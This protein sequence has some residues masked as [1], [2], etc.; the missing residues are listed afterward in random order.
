MRSF[1]QRPAPRRSCTGHQ[2]AEPSVR[3][4]PMVPV[5]SGRAVVRPR[6]ALR[7]GHVSGAAAAAA[8]TGADAAGVDGS[9]P[10]SARREPRVPARRGHSQ[11]DRSVLAMLRS[12]ERFCHQPRA[13]PRLRAS[14]PEG[15]ASRDHTGRAAGIAARHLQ[16]AEGAPLDSRKSDGQP[17][18]D[19]MEGE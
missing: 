15:K 1:D 14:S 16:A 7:Q 11:L 5:Y 9:L 4:A 3:G 13:Q 10:H 2:I 19:G 17:A 18:D 6:G 12:T 8:A